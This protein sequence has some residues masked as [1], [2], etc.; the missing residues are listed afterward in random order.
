MIK[1]IVFDFDGVIIDSEEIK[2]KGYSLMFSEFGEDIPQDAV[3][4]A[5]QTHKQGGVGRL[6]VI[7]K[8]VDLLGKD[9]SHVGIY[10]ERYAHVVSGRLSKIAVS[11]EV[12]G[13]LGVVHSRF[14]LYINSLT[15]DEELL[16][17]VDRLGIKHFFTKVLGASRSKVENLEQIATLEKVK[18]AEILFIGDT[19]GDEDA[20]LNYGCEFLMID[21][22]AKDGQLTDCGNPIIQSLVS[23]PAYC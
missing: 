2:Q 6:A 17:L 14:P 5:R 3:S 4:S 9:D 7:H 1:V 12:I 8:I 10:A 19:R 23:I 22:F 11:Q 15:P 21:K 18:P 16:K 20:A 13:V